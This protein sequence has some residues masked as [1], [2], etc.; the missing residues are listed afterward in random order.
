M[1]SVRSATLAATVLAVTT[2][3]ASCTAG[4]EPAPPDP[5][6]TEQPDPAPE[7]PEPE[8]PTPEEAGEPDP[9]AVVV[10]VY[11]GRS[12][13]DWIWVEPVERWVEVPDEDDDT[14]ALAALRSLFAH[15]PDDPDLFSAVPDGVEVLATMRDGATLTVDVDGSMAATSGGSAQEVAFAEQLAHTAAA[16]DGVTA[17]RL[18]IAGEPVDELWGHLDWSMPIEP[19]PFALSPITIER[20]Q[21][22]ATVPAGE[23]V[24]SG[25]ATVFEANFMIR[26]YDES[27]TLLAETN[28]MASMGAPERGT[29]SH[30]FAID[31]PGSYVVEVEED[32]PSGGEGRTPLVV[33]RPFEVVAP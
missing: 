25:Q 16:L 10:A 20:P 19:D 6:P 18:M 1:R 24:A 5:A 3:L 29:W 8:P 23:V 14:V 17:V 11:F 13:D 2:L 31:E 27:G 28:V 9:L 4:S 12:T 21:L 33:R 30:A 26:L 15:A 7:S 22:D 32:D